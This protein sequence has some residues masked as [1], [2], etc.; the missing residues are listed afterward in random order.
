MKNIK[1]TSDG[2]KVSVI[3]QINTT[4]FIVQEIF[5][6]EDGSEIPSGEKFVTK[7]LHEAPVKSWQQAI[8][9]SHEKEIE[10]L[11]QQESTLYRLTQEKRKELDRLSTMVH[12]SLKMIESVKS[13]DEI[14]TLA[15]FLSGN[16]HFLV[17]ERYYEGF[18][19]I[20]Q[21]TAI[22]PNSLDDR[23][24]LCSVFGKTDG[25]LSYE[26]HQHSDISGSSEEVY[27]FKTKEDALSFITQ[28]CEEKIERGC[29]DKKWMENI[30]ELGVKLSAAMK[31][32]F[33]ENVSNT[34][35]KNMEYLKREEER[36]KKQIKELQKDILV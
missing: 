2:K 15:M 13:D 23:L 20:S 3:G 16:I 28:R 26:L 1:Y 10:K 4:D 21:E 7:S 22:S 30:T 34:A 11:R 6:T 14:E 31:R 19:I 32:K 29:S 8:I 17:V 18:K 27:P 36:Y 5:L 25:S 35:K 12:D 24:R 9:Q 33:K